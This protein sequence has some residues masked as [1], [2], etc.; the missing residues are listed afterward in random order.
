MYGSPFM[1]AQSPGLTLAAP[2]R[3]NTSCSPI[4]GLSMTRSLRTSADPYSL[5]TTAFI[6]LGGA[7]SGV[8]RS[9]VAFFTVSPVHR[10]NVAIVQS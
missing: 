1:I 7:L 9:S 2:T 8:G 3:T 10:F 5:W 6:V 4:S